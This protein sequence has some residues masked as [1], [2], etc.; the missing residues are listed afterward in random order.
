MIHAQPILEALRAFA[1]VAQIDI[2]LFST[3]LWTETAAL[4]EGLIEKDIHFPESTRDCVLLGANVFN[5]NPL[6]KSARA[7]ASKNSDYDLIDL[8]TIDDGYLQRCT[9]RVK[10]S[11]NEYRAK[12]PKTPWGET[13][14]DQYKIFSRKMVD[15]A[16]ERTMI[17]CIVPPGITH[18]DGIR[19]IAFENSREM[20]LFAG[21]MGSVPYDFFVKTLD[22]KS[23]V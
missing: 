15:P 18:T 19:G 11:W 23:V 21:L 3:L 4:D 1:N 17:S 13:Y 5:M 12:L 2:P 16:G 10:A 14:G 7:G 20:C 8:S 9:Y 22:R 6:F